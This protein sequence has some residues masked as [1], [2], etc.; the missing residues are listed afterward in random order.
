[1]NDEK[2]WIRSY[3]DRVEPSEE[4]EQK[5]LAL[6]RQPRRKTPAR[7]K[8]LAAAAVMV[9][10]SLAGFGYLK[11]QRPAPKPP[12]EA[13]QPVQP[14]ASVQA[15]DPLEPPPT[16]PAVHRPPQSGQT[17][18]APT[19]PLPTEP[20]APTDPA[21][22]APTA[23]ESNPTEAPPTQPKPTEAPPTEPSPTE[24]TDSEA[25][26]YPTE[27]TDPTVPEE[28]V[29]LTD[30]TDQTE[31]QPSEP[32][33]EALPLV[34]AYYMLNGRDLVVVTNTRDDTETFLD[35]T[36]LLDEGY[37][38]GVQQIQGYLVWIEI[39]QTTRGEFQV[40][41]TPYEE[42]QEDTP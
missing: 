27:P 30:P 15:T 7:L 16:E 22:T 34:A 33:Q 20:A 40:E 1:M 3:Y 4:F 31:P 32:V 14:A 9:L 24:P 13:L 17:E 28:S 19:Q 21:P 12:V 25:P 5:L 42:Q 18:P 41:L 36:G 23:T 6:A 37:Y 8:P 26:T 2:Q 29:D 39:R 11:M 35:F 10:L 38:R